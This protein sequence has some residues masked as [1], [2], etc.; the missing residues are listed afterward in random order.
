MS[1]NFFFL[2]TGSR[3]PHPTP[4]PPLSL[5]LGGRVG[6]AHCDIESAVH[7]STVPRLWFLTIFSPI[8]AI[9]VFLYERNALR[10]LSERERAREMKG[11][12]E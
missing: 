3:L 7:A 5:V 9:H 12:N 6:K 8:N 2:V 4:T 1:Y 10:F 11:K